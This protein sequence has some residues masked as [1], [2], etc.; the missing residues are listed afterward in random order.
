MKKLFLNLPQL[1]QANWWIEIK[2]TQP[3]CLYYFGPFS[4]AEEAET[5]HSGYVDDLLQEGAETLESEIKCC[6]PTRLT[7]FNSDDADSYGKVEVR[8]QSSYAR[9]QQAEKKSRSPYGG[10]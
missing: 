5:F 8:R 7:I 1:G 10:S 3:L 6:H 9:A 2:T 4:N